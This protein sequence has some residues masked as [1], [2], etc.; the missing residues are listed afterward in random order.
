MALTRGR[1]RRRSSNSCVKNQE[2]RAA[3][4]LIMPCTDLLA[5]PS[6]G[7]YFGFM[8]ILVA[9]ERTGDLFRCFYV[10]ADN[11][12]HAE[13]LLR[14]AFP[15][16]GDIPWHPMP[17]NVGL[18]LHLRPNEVMEWQ[19]GRRIVVDSLTDPLGED[20]QG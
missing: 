8:A 17:E 5:S 10:S 18:A 12:P 3:Q 19:I 6:E 2:P 20:D 11:Q 7:A 14:A 13:R 1:S 4:V 16:V 9:I 15:E